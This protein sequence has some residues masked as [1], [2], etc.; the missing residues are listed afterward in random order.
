MK[1]PTA[2][3]YRA[4]AILAISLLAATPIVS[5]ADAGRVLQAVKA[6]GYLNCGV[7]EG[8]AGFSEKDASGRWTGLDAD[9]CR[10]VAAAALGDAEKVRFLPLRSSNRFPALQA[11]RI[12]LLV[13]NTTWT[14]TREALL[15]VQ[16]PAVLYYDGQAFMVAKGAR[17]RTPAD[18]HGATVCVVKGTTHVQNLV[19]YFGA[20]RLAVKPLVIDSSSEAAA[21]FFAGR[22]RAIT[23]DASQLAA[24]RLRAPGGQQNYVILPERISKEP[25]GPVVRDDD[26]QWVTLVRWVLYALILAEEQ[27]ITRANIDARLQTLEG[28]Y[29]RSAGGKSEWL[30]STLGVQGDWLARAVRA[31]GN[32]GELFN[33]HVGEGSPLKLERGLNRLWTQGGLMY[34]PP[35]D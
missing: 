21:A 1:N 30:A 32:Y 25:L 14:L 34:A 6:R 7:S 33:R 20:R 3:F 15:K 12:D 31:V 18:L 26:V 28:S 11:G 29:L 4:V 19:E 10:A 24:T 22:C 17:I 8:I 2:R 13:R 5:Q 16:V 27:G 35:L 9:F 23:S